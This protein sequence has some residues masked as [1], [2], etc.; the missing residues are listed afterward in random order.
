MTAV[1]VCPTR[2]AYPYPVPSWAV[3]VVTDSSPGIGRARNVGAES[4]IAE[5]NLTDDDYLVFVDDDTELPQYGVAPPT[6][7]GMAVP[8]YK[9]AWD[10]YAEDPGGTMPF[11]MVNA[12]NSLGLGPMGIGPCLAVRVAIWNFLGGYEES[13]DIW[14]DV[15]FTA[16]AKA[17]G[18]RWALW[19]TAVYVHRR[20]SDSLPEWTAY[21][22]ELASRLP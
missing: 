21:R 1:L 8:I 20:N 14:E 13:E 7:F 2:D 12:V 10:G 6:K 18:V 19:K 16:M 4:A 9:P 5:H 11:S 15:M 17:R 22:K 3:G